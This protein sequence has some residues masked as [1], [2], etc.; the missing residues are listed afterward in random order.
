MNQTNEIY[1]CIKN[2]DDYPY[3][4]YNERYTLIS[5]ENSNF[6][7]YPYRFEKK[8]CIQSNIYDMMDNIFLISQYE[9][10]TYLYPLGKLREEKINQIFDE[11]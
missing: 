4:K 9:V 6:T 11:G 5:I 10:D 7:N 1:I 3:F 8:D 2:C